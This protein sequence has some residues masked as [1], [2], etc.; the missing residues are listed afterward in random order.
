MKLKPLLR[1]AAALVA[2]ALGASSSFAQQASLTL[3]NCD[4]AI[5]YKN[6]TPWT[7]TKTGAFTPTN[8]N[9]PGVGTVT[10]TVTATKGTKSDNF[11]EVNG[12]V[13]IKNSGSA[14]A[15]IGNIVVNLQK[16]AT[17]P[18]GQPTWVSAAADMADATLGN[19]ATAAHIAKAA[20]SE[21]VAANASVGANNYTTPGGG[22]GVFVKTAGSGTIAFTDVNG[23]TAFSLVPEKVIPPDG[24]VDLKYTATFNNSILG[25]PAGAQ[26]RTEVIVSFGNAGG[27]GDSGASSV[28]IDINGSG[29]ID[30]DEAHVRS[31]PCRTSKDLPPLEECNSTVILMDTDPDSISKS[32]TV[33]WDSFAT[34]IG[35][36]LGIEAI[37]DTA[38]RTVTVNVAGGANGG[39]VCNTAELNGASHSVFVGN[40]EFPCC[41]G[42]DL[43]A[44]S[45]VDVPKENAEPCV[46]PGCDPTP[47]EGC[48]YTQGGW[49][50][51]PH[52]NNV[53][54]LLA[55]NF[56]AVYPG[57][58]VTIGGTK[59]ITFKTDTTVVNGTAQNS[60]Q[61]PPGAYDIV[62]TG[63]A[64][65]KYTY[66]V[67]V[68]LTAVEAIGAFL[69]AVGGTAGVLTDDLENPEESSAGVFGEQVLAL[70]LNVD[71]GAAG[72]ITAVGG[73]TVCNTGTAADG[74]TIAQILAAA[75]F[76]LGGGTPLPYAATSISQLNDLVTLLNEAF[77]NCVQSDWAKGHICPP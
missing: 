70:Q 53:G 46:G 61:I 34:T 56:A 40:Y 20:S 18:G 22:E 67:G 68:T 27:R 32:G 44:P 19:A 57:G 66:K 72:I 58:E 6:N 77:D 25:L 60:S 69:R 28:N 48:T 39:Q 43:D 59:T 41:T 74:Q 26:I 54:A 23:N 36:G 37:T 11:I 8:P 63:L 10:W 52:G 7:L 21:N 42:V 24:V 14:D 13:S 4:T 64:N 17:P 2:L 73:Y 30:E 51:E 75:N 62:D 16:R 49:G 71:F 29:V 65:P 50:A 55:N 35:G 33:S 38:V 1:A 15:T 5:C 31:V 47:L 12:F 3:Q 76:A 9:V 45:C